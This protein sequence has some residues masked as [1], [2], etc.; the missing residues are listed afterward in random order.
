MKNIDGIKFYG[1]YLDVVL[2]DNS[3]IADLKGG[4]SSSRM[5]RDYTQ[6]G[7]E[8]WYRVSYPKEIKRFEGMARPSRLLHFSN[9]DSRMDVKELT[10][11]LEKDYHR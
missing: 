5:C 8:Q 7:N 1:N 9:F 6:H 10:N 11:I 4:E 3:S 2:T